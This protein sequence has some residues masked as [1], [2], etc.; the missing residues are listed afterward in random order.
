[1]YKQ[2][3]ISSQSNKHA[4]DIALKIGYTLRENIDVE[5]Y[6]AN[7]G[8]ETAIKAE[9]IKNNVELYLMINC[10]P[11]KTFPFISIEGKDSKLTQF[12]ADS[13]ENKCRYRVE[14]LSS[15]EDLQVTINYKTADFNITPRRSSTLV[16]NHY[17]K[18]A[19][20][21]VDGIS[22]SKKSEGEYC[23]ICNEGPF[24]ALHVHMRIHQDQEETEKNLNSIKYLPTKVDFF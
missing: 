1:M 24:K 4:T 12:I 19:E 17:S 16:N 6:Y 21:I 13:I 5:T 18:I 8:F 22:N 11:T 9:Q 14:T 23:N 2:I 3:G 20:A 10:L 15:D 7:S